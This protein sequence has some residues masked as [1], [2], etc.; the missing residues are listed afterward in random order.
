MTTSKH[1]RPYAHTTADRDTRDAQEQIEALQ[2]YRGLGTPPLLVQPEKRRLAIYCRG[3]DESSV[4]RQADLC[5][6]YARRA[7][8]H[9]MQTTVTDVGGTRLALAHLRRHAREGQVDLLVIESLETLAR[10][11]QDLREAVQELFEDGFRTIATA[12]G[13]VLRPTTPFGLC[14]L[15]E[16]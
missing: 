1:V 11:A 3:R 15:T 8:K 4:K 7:F 9:C 10:N 12:D 13:A 2:A 14:G 6:R 5:R 16:A